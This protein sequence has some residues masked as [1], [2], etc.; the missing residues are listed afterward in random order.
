VHAGGDDPLIEQETMSQLNCEEPKSVYGNEKGSEIGLDQSVLCSFPNANLQISKS[1]RFVGCS[2]VKGIPQLSRKEVR[3]QRIK[4]C[5]SFLKKDSRFWWVADQMKFYGPGPERNKIIDAFWKTAYAD[6]YKSEREMIRVRGRVL[7]DYIGLL[8]EEQ[9][10]RERSLR[11]SHVVDGG[12]DAHQFRVSQ[13]LKWE[14]ASG[15]SHV[16]A[17]GGD[18][19]Q[20]CLRGYGQE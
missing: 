8:D 18:S 19:L 16:V 2:I 11:P 4:E 15:P 13:I 7:S 1:S 6:F 5:E 9:L 17:G 20:D 3:D 10:E 14:R 12:G